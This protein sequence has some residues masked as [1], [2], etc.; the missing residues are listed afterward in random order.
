MSGTQYGVDLIIRARDQTRSGL[1]SATRSM[2]EALGNVGGRYTEATFGGLTRQ[3]FK[4]AV[5]VALNVVDDGLRGAVDV[6]QRWRDGELD[7]S[8]GGV[9]T[10]IATKFGESLTDALSSIP[11]AGAVGQLLAEAFDA[12]TGGTMAMERA[13]EAA[14]SFGEQ[15]QLLSS[16]ADQAGKNYWQFIE[17]LRTGAQE[18]DRYQKLMRQGMDLINAR[19]EAARKA[20]MEDQA[21]IR[22][23]QQQRQYDIYQLEQDIERLKMREENAR[24]IK[25][26]EAERAKQLAEQ[27]R[28]QEAQER[29]RQRRME[30][31]RREAERAQD[32]ARRAAEEAQEKERQRLQALLAAEERLAGVRESRATRALVFRAGAAQRANSQ[33]AGGAAGGLD[34]APLLR[35]I[36]QGNDQNRE[37][38]RLL[39]QI[40]D[41]MPEF[42]P[43]T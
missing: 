23:A 11:I 32:E 5:G 39:G 20:A 24:R 21:Q 40:S 29:E 13:H 10:E 7:D 43:G 14:R 38:A 19:A 33:A 18:E 17:H 34:L 1:A 41:R 28:R 42:V 36:Q 12:V 30:E 8:I 16:A 26:E 31:Q 22:A 27:Q 2:Q 6:I 25:E 35:S 15:L 9:A 4:G 37:I 3:I